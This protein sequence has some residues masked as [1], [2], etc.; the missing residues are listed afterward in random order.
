MAKKFLMMSQKKNVVTNIDERKDTASMRSLCR[1]HNIQV[2]QYKNWKDQLENRNPKDTCWGAMTIHKGRPSSLSHLEDDIMTWFCE[3][4]NYGLATTINM[5]VVHLCSINDEFRRKT[6]RAQIQAVC[7]ILRKN[8]IV[9]RCVT[10]TLQRKP[11]DTK[12]SALEFVSTIIPR[13]IGLFQDQ[14]FILNMDET[15]VYFSVEFKRTLAQRG[16]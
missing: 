5:C 9:Y 16:A 11:E 7:R 8:A 10:H 12:T 3:R 6:K 15:P 1:E 2:V 13:M 14:R 4:K